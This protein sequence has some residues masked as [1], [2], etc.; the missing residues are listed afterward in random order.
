ML[1][2]D[3]DGNIGQQFSLLDDEG[4]EI[5]RIDLL[6]KDKAKNTY[7]VIELKKGRSS[8]K[9]VCQTLRYMG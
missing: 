4:E 6:A 7:V 8:D 2:E 1:W 9:V 5:G 3:E